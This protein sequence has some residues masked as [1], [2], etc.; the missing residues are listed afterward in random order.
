VKLTIGLG[1]YFSA[2]EGR[3]ALH[4]NQL[5]DIENKIPRFITDGQFLEKK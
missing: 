4:N 3:F 2:T 5:G 1:Q